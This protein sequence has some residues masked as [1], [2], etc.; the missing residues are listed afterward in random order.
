MGFVDWIEKNFVPPMTWGNFGVWTLKK[1]TSG[2]HYTCWMPVFADQTLTLSFY[3][4]YAI[5]VL[6]NGKGLPGVDEIPA[7]V[8]E[9]MDRACPS[10]IIGS[11]FR[12]A[13]SLVTSH[14]LLDYVRTGRAPR[15]I[16]QCDGAHFMS[17]HLFLLTR[18]PSGQREEMQPIEPLRDPRDPTSRFKFMHWSNWAPCRTGVIDAKTRLALVSE[19]EGSGCILS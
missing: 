6:K 15:N 3:I 2:D 10:Y 18:I 5:A 1:V 4:N 11:K 16:L 8:L 9:A 7:N 14:E 17:W 12:T 13:W 19:F